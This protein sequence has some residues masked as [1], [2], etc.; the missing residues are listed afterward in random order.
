MVHA[1]SRGS[2]YTSASWGGQADTTVHGGTALS[3]RRR[4][5]AAAPLVRR[6][7]MAVPESLAQILTCLV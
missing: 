2:G 3:T 7:A 4:S 6:T 1:R 5:I